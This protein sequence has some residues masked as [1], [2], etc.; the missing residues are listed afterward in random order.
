MQLG[1]KAGEIIWYYKT[2]TE[3][4]IDPKGISIT[5]Y[6][7]MLMS[8]MKDAVEI[9][10]YGDSESIASQV[11]GI[12]KIQRQ[13]HLRVASSPKD[14]NTVHNDLSTASMKLLKS[15]NPTRRAFHDFELEYREMFI[16]ILQMIFLI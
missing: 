4:S 10:G 3:V 7:E 14:K 15:A 12:K 2:D 6:K 1:K 11:F 5:K 9:L 13:M 16:L 8:T